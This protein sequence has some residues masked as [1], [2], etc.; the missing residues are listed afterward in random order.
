MDSCD[1][2][3]QNRVYQSVTSEHGLLLELW[4]YNHRLECLATAARKVLNLNMLCL[5]LLDQLALQ[6]LGG[7]PCGRVGHSCVYGGEGA[8]G[9]R[10]GLSLVNGGTEEVP[11]ASAQEG[12]GAGVHQ[13]GGERLD[14]VQRRLD[15]ETGREEDC[16][17]F[18]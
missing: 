6:S 10:E 2:G 9:D 4:G 13:V 17:G 16:A 1:F 14:R 15:P 18:D 7:H 12:G 8:R 3:L 11:A 5:Q